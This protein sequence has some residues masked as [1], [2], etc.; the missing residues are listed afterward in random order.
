MEKLPF[1]VVHYGA[2]DPETTRGGVE[3]FA[4]RLRLIFEEVTFMT[5]ATRDAARVARE[6]L[7]VICDN[8]FVTDWPEE[9]PVIGFQHGVAQVKYEA[10]GTLGRWRMARRQRRAARRANVVWVANSY[11]V[12]ETF[13]RLYGNKAAHV[14]HY[15]VDV[16]RFDARLENE[17]SR[18]VLH[19]GREPHKGSRILPGLARAFPEWRFEPLDCAPEAVAERMRGARMFVHLS[20]YE[21]NSVVCN[22]AMAMNLP[23]LFTDVGLMRDADRPSEVALIDADV[24]FRNPAALART[25]GAFAASLETRSYRPREWIMSHATPLIAREKWALAMADL[26]ARRR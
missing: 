19:D 10:T 23:C 24:A 22:E 20:R 6:R 9:M 21:G 3:T 2:N 13:G 5:P 12:G 17:G 4:R 15:P 16:E 26:A 14:I 7:P 11:W 8:Q 25:F 18:L 1:H